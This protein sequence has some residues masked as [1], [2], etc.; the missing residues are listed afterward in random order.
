MEEKK[1]GFSKKKRFDIADARALQTR[2]NL[3]FPEM[4]NNSKR[5]FEDLL[6]YKKGKNLH[7]FQG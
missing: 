5:K 1:M 3:K 4:M 7:D 6:L 2:I